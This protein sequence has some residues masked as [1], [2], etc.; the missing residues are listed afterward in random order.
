VQ[1]F[2]DGQSVAD[3]FVWLTRYKLG[4]KRLLDAM[5]AATFQ[6]FGVK[7][8]ISKNDKGFMVLDVFEIVNF[9]S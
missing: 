2:P 6:G 8:I 9:R 5:L 4:R 7:R 3:F 1:V